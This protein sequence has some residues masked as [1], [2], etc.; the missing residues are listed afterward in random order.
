MQRVD[1][2]FFKTEKK[3]SV[4]K[5]KRIHVDGACVKTT[6]TKA[7]C[8]RRDLLCNYNNGDLFTREDSMLSQI[9]CEIDHIW[10]AG[11]KWRT[12]PRR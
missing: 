5:H 6:L 10:P 4:F 9:V 3:I 11:D 2:D 8:E 12:D 7:P 1:A